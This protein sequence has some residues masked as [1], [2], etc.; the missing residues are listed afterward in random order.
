ME[1]IIAV[2]DSEIERLNAAKA[3]L[4]GSTTTLQKRPKKTM[5]AKARKLIAAA[6]RKRWA[7]SKK[8][9]REKA[10]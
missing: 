5:S 7:E 8:L 3:L 2:I 9:Q 6:Q 10:A 4:Q 1:H